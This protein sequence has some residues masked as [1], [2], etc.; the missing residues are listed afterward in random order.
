MPTS[1]SPVT[2]IVCSKAAAP[3]PVFPTARVSTVFS[4]SFLPAPIPA[5]WTP[6]AVTAFSFTK[7]SEKA[8]GIGMDISAK[9]LQSATA[10]F[11]GSAGFRFLK[12]DENIEPG[13]CDLIFC[14]E[15]LEHVSDAAAVLDISCAHRRPAPA[16]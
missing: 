4:T 7:R 10:R 9:M 5:P 3:S 1:D 6:D 11:S 2:S 14:T 16:C 15:T 8:S 13:S 12:P